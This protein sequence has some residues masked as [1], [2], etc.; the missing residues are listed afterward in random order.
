MHRSLLLSFLFLLA[1]YHLFAQDSLKV[2]DIDLEFRPRMEFRDGYSSLPADSLSP[3]YFVSSRSRLNLNFSHN[4]MTF[5]MSLQD[6]RVWGE[7]GSGS[8]SGFGVF[9]TYASLPM[10]KHW[11][12]KMGRQAVE[13]D[14][15]RLFSKANWSQASKAHDG[16][17]F[18]FKKNKWDSQLMA[19]YN[20][21]K[22][23]VFGSSYSGNF[24]KILV[25]QFLTYNIRN[26]WYFMVLNAFDGYESPASASTLYVRGTSGGRVTYQTKTVEGTVAGYYQY[27]QL[28][29]GAQVAAFYVQPEMMVKWRPVN[30]RLGM[31]YV[32]GQQAGSSR[33]NS[34]ST[35]YGVA[36]KFM[37]HLNYFTSFPRDTKS[38]G[39]INPYLFLDFRL[40]DKTRLKLESHLFF[41]ESSVTGTANQIIDPYLGAEGDLKIKY[42][43]R[44]DL[45]LDFGLSAMVATQ[46]MEY[47]K[48]GSHARIPVYSFL[49]LTWKPNLLHLVVPQ[50]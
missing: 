32:S 35:L 8:A 14:N 11:Q 17:N 29:T 43:I 1:T 34:F 9:E 33:D 27:G 13:L 20:Q 19:F 12:V 38:G 31:E 47:L 24:Y 49:M 21:N 44:K 45:S 39:L 7:D 2:L 42:D 26:K 36:F 22:E 46:S 41:L 5:H 6:V 3:A 18:L 30:I 37:G 4:R 10:G 50:K 48:G 25:N 15:G 40:S 16:I 28:A 23:N